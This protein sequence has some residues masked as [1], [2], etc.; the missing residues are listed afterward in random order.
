MTGGPVRIAIV[1]AGVI[2]EWHAGVIRDLDGAD[3]VA[4]VDPMAM[5]SSTLAGEHGARAFNTLD[6]ALGSVEID[7]V[8]VC[9]PSGEHASVAVAA[10]GADKHVLIEKPVEISRDAVAK[11]RQAAAR[12]DR[13]IGVVSQHRF[14]ISTEIVTELVQEGGLGRLTSAN[15]SIAWWRSQEYYDSGDWRGT[16]DLDGGGALM[17]QGVHT[18]DLLIA[19]MGAPREVF[20]YGATL[21]HERIDVEDTAVAVVKFDS[22]ALGVIHATT[23]A[24]PGLS[25]RLQIHGDRGSAIIDDDQL[26][27]VH[28]DGGND[29]ELNQIEDFEERIEVQRSSVTGSREPGAMSDAHV[30][31]YREFLDAVNGGP[32]PRV[33]L[34]EGALALETILAIYESVRTGK[35]VPIHPVP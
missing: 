24:F 20:A 13:V 34:D 21:A 27:F 22:G 28:R 7:V 11:I 3:L 26:V 19:V 32:K 9:V 2:G 23:A 8:A 4:V 31:Q 16:W 30:Y 1:G 25:A 33:G 14:D 6:E 10:L 35:P 12:S 15:V 18:V 5:R 17:N 29:S